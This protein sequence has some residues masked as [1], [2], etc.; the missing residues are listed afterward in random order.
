M[1]SLSKLELDL[2]FR[3]YPIISTQMMSWMAN[4]EVTTLNLSIFMHEQ[5]QII[6]KPSELNILSQ[7]FSGARKLKYLKFC[8]DKFSPVSELLRQTAGV[9]LSKDEQHVLSRNLKKIKG[10]KAV[11]I[12]VGNSYFTDY[13]LPKFIDWLITCEDKCKIDLSL[14]FGWVSEDGFR[15]MM[16]KLDELRMLVRP[17]NFAL[18]LTNYGKV[19]GMRRLSDWIA[20]YFTQSPFSFKTHPGVNEKKKEM[21]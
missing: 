4:C 9:Q 17:K 15:M 7:A 18:S 1:K 20:K 6:L 5:S 10:L 8:F 3:V 19:A 12:S 14:N 13:E 11:S 16:D 2:E 21:K